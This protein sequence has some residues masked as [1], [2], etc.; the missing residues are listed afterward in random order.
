MLLDN[1]AAKNFLRRQGKSLLQKWKLMAGTEILFL[2]FWGG[3]QRH[4]HVVT[5]NKR[6]LGILSA[7]SQVIAISPLA[8]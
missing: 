6:G 7:M 8:M 2:F 3:C 5:Y 1:A 4:N